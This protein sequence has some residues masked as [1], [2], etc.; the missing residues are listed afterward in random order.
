MVAILGFNKDQIT[1]A[2]QD[3]YAAV[4]ASP[5]Q[6][7]HFPVGRSAASAVGYPDDWLDRLPEQ[8]VASFAGVGYP[9]RAEVI[10][11]GD[12][13]LDVGCGAGCDALIASQLVGADGKVW[14]LDITPDMVAKL[15]E[16]LKAEGIHNVE[17]I[18]ADAERIPLPDNSVDVVT[19]NGAL[20]L[21]PDKRKAFAEL[22]RVLKPDGRV[23]IADIVIARPVP[24]G[25]KSDPELWAECVVG[26]A[27]DEDYLEQFREAGF[28]DVEVLNEHDY[29]EHSPSADTKRIAGMLGARTMEL[30]MLRPAEAHAPAYLARLARRLDPRRLSRVTD[31][32]LWGVVAAL[33]AVIA[34]YGTLAVVGLLSLL[35]LGL[36]LDEGLWALTIAGGAVLA[37]LATG[38]NLRR[39]GQGWP[40]ALAVLGG[41]I[42]VYVMFVQYNQLA[43]IVGFVILLSAVGLDVYAVYRA[44]CVPKRGERQAVSRSSEAAHQAGE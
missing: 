8:T 39:H 37:M 2:V 15:R 43:E 4:A 40:L 35:G 20:N 17:V 24:L 19:S 12:T 11:P 28:T 33:A 36:A 14:A 26:A 34:C 30:R 16:T 6:Y 29:F 1:A 9:F 44:E 7:F 31:R 38:V 21:V 25:G 42:I 22:F 41:G 10:R 3:M 13:V 23:Q 27:I 32:G 18:E 5:V